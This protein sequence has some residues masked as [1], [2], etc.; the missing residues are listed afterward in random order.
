MWFA[1]TIT[2]VGDGIE[3]EIN[4]DER[5]LAAMPPTGRNNDEQRVPL[6]SMESMESMEMMGRRGDHMV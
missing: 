3:W 6:D 4:V 2:A 5:A 1:P